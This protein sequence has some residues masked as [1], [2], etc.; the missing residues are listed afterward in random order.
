[1]FQI[2]GMRGCQT[3]VIY[4]RESHLMIVWGRADTRRGGLALLALG[5]GVGVRGEGGLGLSVRVRVNPDEL[6]TEGGVC[7]RLWIVVGIRGAPGGGGHARR[8]RVRR[9]VREI[10]QTIAL[11][12][13]TDGGAWVLVRGAHAG[14]SIVDRGRV[15]LLL[16]RVGGG[17]LHVDGRDVGAAGTEGPLYRLVADNATVVLRGR[18]GMRLGERHLTVFIIEACC[19]R[20]SP[21]AGGRY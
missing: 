19:T 3:C 17:G 20:R 1:M 5:V 6:R 10:W 2:T 4:T 13:G 9:R 11:R 7:R 21:S 15:L 18:V 16:V 14:K 8:D 12:G